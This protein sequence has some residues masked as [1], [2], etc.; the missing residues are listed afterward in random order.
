M[1]FLSEGFTISGLSA[2]LDYRML[3]HDRID[4]T[5]AYQGY[6]Y[7][8]KKRKWYQNLHILGGCRTFLSHIFRP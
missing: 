1:L 5:S 3:V 2:I 8:D 7:M 4:N 6:N